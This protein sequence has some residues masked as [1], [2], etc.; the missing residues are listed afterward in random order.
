MAPPIIIRMLV[1]R[2]GN[3]VRIIS[4]LI[5]SHK[6]DLLSFTIYLQGNHEAMEV[7]W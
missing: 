6:D 4:S 5:D 3:N 7:E 2:G 1:S